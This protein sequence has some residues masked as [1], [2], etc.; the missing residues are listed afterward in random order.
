MVFIESID[1]LLQCHNDVCKEMSVVFKPPCFSLA[2]IMLTS[3]GCGVLHF[4]RYCKTF[5][6]FFTWT[7][8]V[9]YF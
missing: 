1:Y 7:D 9:F 2:K 8:K 3:V 6:P 5:Q 4:D